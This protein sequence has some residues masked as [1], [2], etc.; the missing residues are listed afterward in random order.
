MLSCLSSK[1]R[2]NSDYLLPEER[3]FIRQGAIK[4]PPIGAVFW[5]SGNKLII[6]Q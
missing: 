1:K 3:S 5:Q 6:F 2:A 4:K